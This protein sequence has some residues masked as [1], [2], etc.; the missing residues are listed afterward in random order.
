MKNIAKHNRLLT[1]VNLVQNSDIQN[2]LDEY[3]VDPNT[4]L[5]Q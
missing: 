3:Q 1:E 5:T 2:M 4:F